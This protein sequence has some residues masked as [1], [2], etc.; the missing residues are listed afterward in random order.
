M[1]NLRLFIDFWNFQL[2][3][4]NRAGGALC[5]W[6]AVPSVLLAEAQAILSASQLGSAVLHETRVY[7][8][9][10]PGRENKLKSWLDSFLDKQPGFAVIVKERH[11]RQKSIHCRAC[12]TEHEDCPRCKA[13]LGR[14]SEKMVDSR[15][16]TDMLTLAWDGS[17]DVALL[18][19]SDADMVP[20][21]ESL[22]RHNL[23]V[24]NATWRGNGHE[25]AKTSWASF[26]L[27]G[28]LEKLKR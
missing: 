13:K 9:Y 4:N 16:V 20:A 6:R 22:Q 7:A 15:I 28:V 24:I 2:N 18:L 19:T 14:A 3:W 25:L 11:W 10:E 8:S 27:D 17:Y 23:K 1:L 26:E 5:N 21:V 12:D